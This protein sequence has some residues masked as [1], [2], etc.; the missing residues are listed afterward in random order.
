MRGALGYGFPRRRIKPLTKR[1]SPTLI[2]TAN[3]EASHGLIEFFLR[4]SLVPITIPNPTVS[5]IG[6]HRDAT[7]SAIPQFCA[8][9]RLTVHYAY[10]ST[11][12]YSQ[13]TQ[14]PVCP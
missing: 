5:T 3:A 8:A 1:R 13:R 12:R 11:F 14:Q 6:L 10:A 4:K 2:G 9:T 7:P